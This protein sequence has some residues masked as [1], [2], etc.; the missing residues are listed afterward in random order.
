MDDDPEN[1]DNMMSG[2]TIKF[3]EYDNY[4]HSLIYNA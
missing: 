1:E 4:G 2:R 3:T